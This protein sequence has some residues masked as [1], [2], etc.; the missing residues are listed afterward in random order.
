MFYG[1]PDIM[2]VMEL[3]M[4]N[5]ELKWLANGGVMHTVCNLVGESRGLRMFDLFTL[6][7]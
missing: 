6:V 7:Q 5:S 2:V 1:M 4:R 3:G